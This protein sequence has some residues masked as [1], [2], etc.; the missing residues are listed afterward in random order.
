MLHSISSSPR[1]LLQQCRHQAVRHSS[2]LQRPDYIVKPRLDY[3]YIADHADELA[4]NMRSRNYDPIDPTDFQR[5]HQQRKDLYQQ[6]LVLRSQRNTLSKAAAAHQKQ[7]L[8]KA[9]PVSSTAAALASSTR[10]RS[11]QQAQSIK[12]DIKRHEQELELVESQLLTQALLIP[13]TIH[14]NVPRGED[15]VVV[16]KVQGDHHG[17]SPDTGDW[18]PLDHVALND[19]LKF[20]DLQQASRV[21][22]SSFYYLQGI[23]AYLELA[24]IQYAMDKAVQRGYL[25]ILTPDIVRTSLANAC[26]FQ[27]RRG[28]SQQMYKINDTTDDN[29]DTGLCLTGTAEIPLA[30]KYMDQIIPQVDLPLR[31]VGFGHSFR[32][33]AGGRASAYRKYDIEAWLPGRK[34]WGEI[35]STSNCTDYQAR[36][37]SIRYRPTHPTQD[38]T[39]FCHTLNGTAMAVPRVIIAILESFQ[40]P[41]GSVEIPKVL[42]KWIPGQPTVISV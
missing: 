15:P 12:A 30:G 35:S 26:G 11:I 9:S 36:R 2:S 3:G 6:L 14:P 25:G 4:N 16:K 41:D 10:D 22:G 1:R 38:N 40:R 37:L 7:H 18:K 13:N 20:M 21:T 33:E 27:P 17:L 8:K 31:C 23:G 32:M 34:T 42:Q 19:R 39:L 28:E 24:L 29:G 5:L